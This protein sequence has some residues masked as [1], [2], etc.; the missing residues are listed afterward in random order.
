MPRLTARLAVAA[1]L[2]AAVPAVHAQ[3]Y[4]KGGDPRDDLAHGMSNAGIAIE[5]MR[6]LGMAPKSA[7]FDSTRGL[8]FVNSDLAFRGNL[9]YQGN[10]A[11]FTI[12]DVRDPAKPVLVS[13]VPC[14]TSQGDPSIVGH[15]L[16]VSAEGTG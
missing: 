13:E 14:I 7:A 12:W 16:F 6:H 11:G 5:G 3:T 10:F 8:T 4:P 1:A 15:L 2:L 9:V